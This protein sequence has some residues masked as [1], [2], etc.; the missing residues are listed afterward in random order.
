VEVWC[1]SNLRRLR[2]GEEKK[3]IEDRRN[4]RAKYNVRICYEG[5]H[6]E[7]DEDKNLIMIMM[8]VFL[9]TRLAMQRTVCIHRV[10]QARLTKMLLGVDQIY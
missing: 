2:L 6:K 10:R 7:H 1:T 5:G 8:I 9:F 3:K 4:H